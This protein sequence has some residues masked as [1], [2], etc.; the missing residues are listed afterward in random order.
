[1]GK[2]AKGSGQLLLQVGFYFFYQVLFGDGI[3]PQA[4]IFQTHQ[5]LVPV[6]RER[7]GTIIITAGLGNYI[8]YLRIFSDDLPYLRR[9]LYIFL[10]GYTSRKI[11]P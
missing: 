1:M 9:I 5:N 4:I 7:I 10:Y 3:A 8:S 2:R 6:C 11:T